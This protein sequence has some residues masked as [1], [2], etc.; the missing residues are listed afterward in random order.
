[1]TLIAELKR[2]KVF[3]VG[4]AYLVVGWLLIQ[5]A[6]T[7]APQLNL[8]EW[9]PR[10]IT[11]VILLGFPIAILLAWV[12]DVTPD[13]IKLDAAPIGNKRIIVIVATL[14]ALSIGWYWQE[15][16]APDAIGAGKPSIAVLPFANLSGKSDEEYFSDG[17]TEELLNVLAKVPQLKVVARTSVFEFKGKGGDVREI[18][19]KLGVAYIIEGSMRRDGQEVRITAQ[20]VRVSDGFHVWSENYDRKLES[21]FA[22]Q[23][24]IAQRIGEQLVSS[25]VAPATRQARAEVPPEAY[26]S[27]LKGRALYRQRKDMLQAITLFKDAVAR[28]P[29][30]ASGWSSLSLTYETINSY[31]RP[32]QR[33]SLVDPYALCREAA[34]RANALEPDAAMTLHAMAN[35]ARL[36]FRYADAERLYLRSMQVDPTYPDVREDYSELLGYVGRNQDQLRAARQ[37]VTLEP[38]VRNFW[39]KVYNAAIFLDRR[40]VLAEAAAHIRSIDPT[41]WQGVADDLPLELAWGRID[42][43][44]KSLA[45]AVKRAPEVMADDVV[46]MKWATRQPDADDQAVQRVLTY[47]PDA[48]PLIYLAI[49][50][51]ADQVFARIVDKKQDV[52]VRM[53]L[54]QFLSEVPARP[55]L[56]DPRAR[57]L[58]REFGFEAYWREKGWP[59]LCHPLGSGDFECGVDAMPVR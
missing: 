7:I 25:L 39:S 29:K 26:D 1:M 35:V 9:S 40:D 18:G 43:A 42:L 11:F 45:T 21:V 15:H 24:E 44:Q 50:G 56:A 19:R 58:L 37:L 2:R 41:Y 38:F 30:F 36:E 31:T 8:P 3:K 32:E 6:A 16:R 20:L 34:L 54:Y 23:D 5:V 14:L 52:Y 49:R 51:E 47:T 4:A 48:D 59:A 10:L 27:Y 22:L 53:N 57:K 28:A 55:L 13:G 12:L 46:L 17:M 33:T